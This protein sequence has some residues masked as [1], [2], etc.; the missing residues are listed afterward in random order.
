M[1][2]EFPYS[3]EFCTHRLKA[4]GDRIRWTI[5]LLLIGG[6][7]IVAE[8]HAAVEVDPTLL[9]HHLKILRDAGL[10]TGQRTGKNIRYSLAP[11]VELTPSGSGLNLGCCRIALNDGPP[12][13]TTQRG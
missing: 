13:D 9:S 8:L 5:I 1:V 4:I 11:G 7:K 10:I 3:T 12:H 6:P 2:G